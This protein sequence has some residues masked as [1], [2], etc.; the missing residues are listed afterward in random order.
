MTTQKHGMVG[1][2]VVLNLIFVLAAQAEPAARAIPIPE[3][4]KTLLQFHPSWVTRSVTSHDPWGHNGDG[5][6]RGLQPEGEYHT[7]FHA[8]GEGRIMRLWMTVRPEDTDRD[9]QEIKIIVDGK[10]VYSGKPTDFFSGKGPW[11]AP[12]VLDFEPASGAYLSYVPFAYRQEAKILFKGD[13]HYYQINYREG[14]GSSQGPSAEEI[15]QFMSEEWWT[16]APEA[17]QLA[18]VLPSRGFVLAQGAN[19]VAQLSL[20]IPSDQLAK[21]RIR[22]G[23]QEPVPV[24]FFFGLGSSGKGRVDEGWVDMKNTLHYANA[25][26]HLLVTRLPIPLKLG[27]SVRIETTGSE[28][29]KVHYGVAYA[30]HLYPAAQLVT[31]YKEQWAP[32]TVGTMEFVKLS[33]PVQFVSLVEEITDGPE[34]DR[35]YLEGDEMIRLDGMSYPLQ[36]GTGTEDYYNG[37][38]YFLGAHSNP[39]AGEPRF[40]VEKP[41]DSWA[42][43]QFEHAL[44][45]H[46]VLDPI[47]SRGNFAFNMEAGDI[48]N[49]APVHYRTL[50]LAYAFTNLKNTGTEKTP[51][52]QLRG[53]ASVRTIE[54]AW[55]AERSQ[56]PQK[57]TARYTQGLS[58]FTVSCPRSTALAGMFLIRTYD[59]EK[60]NQSARILVNGREEGSFFEAYANSG[61]RLAQNAAWVDLKEGDCASGSV[62]IQLDA[63]ASESPWSE[64]LYQVEFFSNASTN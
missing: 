26:S 23:E 58:E 64:M 15:A 25:E 12:L 28:P 59:A 13:P 34:A 48:G 54:S 22:V 20:S 33:G 40:A 17:N 51:T 24:G 44:Y 3:S 10:I 57:W 2:A 30:D 18:E 41:E 11:K 50:G 63:S 45:R 47:V 60:H 53:D 35:Y 31:Q 32:G 6:G 46:H 21:L 19:T 9:W 27:E 37:G 7:L 38:W 62:S 14:A 1:I 36:H 4:I 52:D 5:N 39:F 55:D 43:A 61:R 42:H 49:F 16:T 56:E 29:V 8:K